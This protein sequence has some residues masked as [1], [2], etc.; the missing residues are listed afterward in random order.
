MFVLNE[1]YF[2]KINFSLF[3]A[4][5]HQVDSKYCNTFKTVRCGKIILDS[6]FPD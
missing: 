5:F 3:L 2:T 1:Y 6:S 4:V